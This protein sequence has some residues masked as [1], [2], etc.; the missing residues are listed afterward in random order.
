[1]K[2]KTSAYLGLI[3]VVTLC[4]QAHAYCR[5]AG[6]KGSYSCGE[7]PMGG[8]ATGSYKIVRPTGGTNKNGNPAHRTTHYSGGQVTSRNRGTR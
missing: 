3:L 5:K 1:M 2:T 6:S 4:G 8:F 7:G